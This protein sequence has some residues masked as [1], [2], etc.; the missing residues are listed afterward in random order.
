[1]IYLSRSAGS[2]K[3]LADKLQKLWL[4]F[5]GESR[6]SHLQHHRVE[7][8]RVTAWEGLVLLT[9]QRLGESW[10]VQPK[11]FKRHLSIGLMARISSQNFQ[12]KL[13]YSNTLRWLA[14]VF[15]KYFSENWETAARTMHSVLRRSKSGQMHTT[16]LTRLT[17]VG[18]QT[19]K[20]KVHD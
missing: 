18:G 19:Y 14:K 2:S 20:G 5:L 9:N 13:S 7:I 8:A 12:Y 10:K 4:P 16:V 11:L 3:A 15:S 6:V 1:M 17:S